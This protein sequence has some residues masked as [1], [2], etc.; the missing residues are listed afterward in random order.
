MG[1]LKCES[2]Q[3]I[4]PMWDEAARH[5]V[6]TKDPTIAFLIKTTRGSHNDKCAKLNVVSVQKQAVPKG[7]DQSIIAEKL[8]AQ[9]ALWICS[10]K[11]TMIIP[12]MIDDRQGYFIGKTVA[13]NYSQE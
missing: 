7:I 10:S 4:D 8:F 12:V 9:S 5:I 2:I 13:Q 11:N 3:I 1:S 6:F